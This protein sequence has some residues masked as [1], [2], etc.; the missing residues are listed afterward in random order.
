M[1]IAP[2]DRLIELQL[3]AQGGDRL[4]RRLIAEDRVGEVAGQQRGDQE[5]EQRDRQ[6]HRDEMQQLAADEAEHVFR[7]SS[8]VSETS[9][10]PL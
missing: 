5:R 1:Q 2:E 10:I 9:M 8:Q 4:R 7:Y 6:Q 3:L